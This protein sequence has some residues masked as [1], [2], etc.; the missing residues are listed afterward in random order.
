MK[1]SELFLNRFLYRDTSQDSETKD[2]AFIS[3]DST[4]AT[5]ASVAAGSAAQDINTGNVFINGAI[6]EP[7]SYILTTGDWGWGQ[8]CAFSSASAT[9]VN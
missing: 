8:T 9:Q 1:L 7:G 2:S 3:A 5:P 6:I 4:P